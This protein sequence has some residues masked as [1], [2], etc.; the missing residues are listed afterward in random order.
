LGSGESATLLAFPPNALARQLIFAV[1]LLEG[2][3]D[4]ER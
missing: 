3:I 4:G 1:R 2:C